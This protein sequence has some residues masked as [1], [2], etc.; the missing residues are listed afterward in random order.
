MNISVQL[1]SESYPSVYNDMKGFKHM[2][3]LNIGNH[4]HEGIYVK[5]NQIAVL[6]NPLLHIYEGYCHALVNSF[7]NYSYDYARGIM[8]LYFIS[9]VN[10]QGATYATAVHDFASITLLKVSHC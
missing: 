7:R 10:Q 6:S 8:T 4:E 3:P 9:I 2:D 5:V 1:F